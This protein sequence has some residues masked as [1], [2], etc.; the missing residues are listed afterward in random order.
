MRITRQ[1]TAVALGLSALSSL[2]APSSEADSKRMQA[3]DR[4]AYEGPVFLEGKSLTD[5][6]ADKRLK[7]QH[8]EKVPVP[9]NSAL[10]YE[11][12]E[13]TFDGSRVRVGVGENGRLLRELIEVSS[14]AWPIKHGLAV[15]TPIERVVEVLGEPDESRTNK[16][17]PYQGE[18]EHVVFYN[19]GAKITKILFDYYFE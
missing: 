13:L 5:L 12:V 3:I 16:V 18:T 17:M 14:P 15:G 10:T 6:T 7:K 1:F 9:S 8:R 4:L 2:A 11:R 19:D